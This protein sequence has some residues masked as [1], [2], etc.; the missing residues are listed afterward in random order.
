MRASSIPLV[1]AAGGE[2]TRIGGAKPAR[3]LAGHT[4]IDRAVSYARTQSRRVA[5]AARPGVD[6]G[7]CAGLPRLDDAASGQGPI[8]AL[9]SA[10][11]YARKLGAGHVAMIGCDLPLLPCDLMARLQ[12]TIAGADAA[13]ASS[14][15]RLHPICGLWRTSAFAALQ[16]YAESGRRSL[17]G[18]AEEVGFAE[19]GWPSEPF[20]PFFNVN[21]QNDLVAAERWLKNRSP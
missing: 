16:A 21:T 2:G 13:L 14:G 7:E 1:I 3:M 4:L 6:L 17:I 15:G 12:T 8:A 9:L 18:F 11:E 5:I 10:L 20:D 19:V